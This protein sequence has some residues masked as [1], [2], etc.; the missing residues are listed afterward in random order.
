MKKYFFIVG[1]VFAILIGGLSFFHYVFLP[2]VI[3][4]A[5]RGG[6]IPVQTIAA[7]AAKRELWS[8]YV[9]AIGTVKAESGIEIAPKTSGVVKVV[10]VESGRKV[11]KGQKLFELD[12]AQEQA[13]LRAQAASLRNAELEL[14]RRKD[15]AA[16]GFASQA[17]LDAALS[18]RDEA[19]AA[20]ERTK[21]VIADKQ[22]VAPWDGE[23]GIVQVDAGA[24]VSPGTALVW[25][26]SVDPVYVDFNVPEQEFSR[27]QKGQKVEAELLAWPGELF[28]GEVS[29]VDARV[30]QDTRSFTVRASFPNPTG[31]IV[32]G[33]FANVGVVSGAAE[34]VITLPQ[35]AVTYSLYGDSVYVVVPQADAQ[36]QASETGEPKLTVERRFVKLGEARDG[37]IAILEGVKEGE[38]AVTAGQ[39]KLMPG[40][41]IRIDNSVALTVNGARKPE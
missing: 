23:A 32:P 1:V 36:E 30:G 21:A 8:P 13:D 11:A 34:N 9:R 4:K 38:E 25:L 39:L 17:D 22:I 14:N 7:E 31:K 27:I 18:R 24:F 29:A 20:L 37:R 26:Q 15:L 19:Q 5:I 12:D 41:P 28:S 2:S 35:T 40:G 3:E 10:H 33:M 6:P 16:K